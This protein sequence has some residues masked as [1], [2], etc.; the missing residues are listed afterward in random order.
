MDFSR[1]DF[2]KA[3]FAC[4]SCVLFL[5]GTSRAGGDRPGQLLSASKGNLAKHKALFYQKL[6][7]KVVRCEICPRRCVVP[8]GGRGYC[9]V[10]E[11]AGGDYFSLVYGRPCTAHVD[12]I[13][14]KPF[15]HFLPGTTA[16]SLATVGCNMHCKFCQNWQISQPKPEE[17]DSFELAPSECAALAKRSNCESVA[18][19]YTEPI[20]F[21]EYTRDIAQACKEAGLKTVVISAGYINEKPLQELLANLSAIKIDLKSFSD[22]Y[23]RKTCDTTLAPVLETLKTIKA[24]GVWLEIVNLVLPTLN[25]SDEEHRKMFEWITKNLGDAVPIHLTR[26]HP[27]YRLKNLPPT[28]E[29]TLHRLHELAKKAG[30]KFPYVG[31][32]PGDPAENTYCPKCGKMLINRKGFRISNVDIISSRCKFCGELIP[33][34]WSP[35]ETNQKRAVVG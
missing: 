8:D 27:T 12:P 32:V 30:L 17:I 21:Y 11:N 25:D 23:Y 26:F 1:R 28:P 24:S 14:K 29:S 16:F 5:R 19:T 22:D 6:D 33:G 7:N 2:L 15:F 3:S 35:N 34:I 18:L 20:V 9:R 31:N 10:R 13:E 4:A